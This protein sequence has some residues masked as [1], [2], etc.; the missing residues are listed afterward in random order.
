MKRDVITKIEI[1][2]S[3]QL[4]ISPGQNKFVQIYRTAREVHWDLKRQTLYSPVPKGWTY[5]DWFSHIVKVVKEECFCQLHL[6]NE[7]VWVNVP[8]SIRD[9]IEQVG[10]DNRLIL[11]RQIDV[12]EKNSDPIFDKIVIEDFDLATVKEI[13]GNIEDDIQLYNEYKIEGKLQ[14]YLENLG[15]EFFPKKFDYFLACYQDSNH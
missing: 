13:I 7:T 4:H 15:Y 11:I 12:F 14:V 3:G 1:D 10:D 8:E 2:V 9:E 6:T 5:V